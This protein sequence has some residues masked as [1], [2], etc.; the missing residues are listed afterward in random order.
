MNQSQSKNPPLTSSQLTYQE[1]IADAKK[2][3]EWNNAHAAAQRTVQPPSQS[4]PQILLELSEENDLHS[5]T[6]GVPLCSL[7]RMINNHDN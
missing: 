5:V 4:T 7:W 6:C 2:R 3:E 1:L